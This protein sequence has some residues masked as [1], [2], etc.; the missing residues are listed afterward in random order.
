MSS[1]TDNLTHLLNQWATGDQGAEDK[2]FPLIYR[3]LR[4]SPAVR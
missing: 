2:V 1:R 4:E 3:E